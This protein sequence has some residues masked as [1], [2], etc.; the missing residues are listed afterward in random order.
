MTTID[1]LMQEV[2]DSYEFYYPES[3]T[4]NPSYDQFI[5]DLSLWLEDRGFNP[6]TL[7]ESQP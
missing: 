7:K 5:S 1:R 4:H 6:L 3:E 2:L